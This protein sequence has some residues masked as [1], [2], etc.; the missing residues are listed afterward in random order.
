MTPAW[1]PG[2]GY[3]DD[4][5]LVAIVL[6]GLLNHVERELVL[7]RWPGDPASV[8]RAGRRRS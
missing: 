5:L 6:D 2:L 7:A 4:A 8:E 1:P 3:L